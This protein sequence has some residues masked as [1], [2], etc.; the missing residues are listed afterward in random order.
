M[1]GLALLVIV[2]VITAFELLALVWILAMG[3]RWPLFSDGSFH[4]DQVIS[5]L[6]GSVLAASGRSSSI[7]HTREQESER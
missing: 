2:G 6:R 7:G 1:V 4:K 5:G 3:S